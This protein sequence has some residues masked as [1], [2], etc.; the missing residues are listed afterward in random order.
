MP[1]DIL[2]V[3]FLAARGEGRQRRGKKGERRVNRLIQAVGQV[4]T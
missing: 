4:K 3:K 1:K 2:N